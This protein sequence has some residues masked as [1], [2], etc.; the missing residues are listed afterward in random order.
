MQHTLWQVF[1]LPSR[2][3]TGH[4]ALQHAVAMLAMLAWSSTNL[5]VT[6]QLDGHNSLGC[7]YMFYRLRQLQL[8]SNATER[9]QEEATFP[10]QCQPQSHLC[11]DVLL[12]MLQQ[13]IL[14]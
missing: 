6:G 11:V 1:F 2:H 9:L 7:C 14:V 3:L 4:H 5:L 12:L 8:S 13:R 10:A